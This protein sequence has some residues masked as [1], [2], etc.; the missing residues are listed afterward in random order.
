MTGGADGREKPMKTERRHDLGTNDLA[1]WT[2]VR[3][4]RIK[5]YTTLLVTALIVLLGMAA[6]GSVWNSNSESQQE[7]AWSEFAMAL[8]TD[9]FELKK[10]HQIASDDLY[11]GTDMQEWAFATWAD[12]QLSLAAQTYLVDRDSS[13]ERLQQIVGIYELLAESSGD[14]QL[15]NRARYGLAQVYE[16][17]NRLEEAR[18]QYDLVKGDFELIARSRADHLLASEA[19]ETY[20]WLAIAELPR[21]AIPGGPGIPGSR[22]AFE[23]DYP[24]ASDGLLDLGPKS[25]AEVFG[26]RDS[27]DAEDRYSTEDSTTEKESFDDLFDDEPDN[28]EAETSETD[29]IPETQPPAD[30]EAST[31]TT[32]PAAEESPATEE[33]VEP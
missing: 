2:A 5:P 13:L 24:D 10:M 6:V 11:S 21:R 19:E 29:A 20:N 7:L 30:T 28:G 23:A 25:L 4:E 31:E 12:Q 3:I 33:S 15:R 17:Q 1:R 9:D 32:E 22:P 16:L 18:S 8:N 26:T 27:D 14:Q